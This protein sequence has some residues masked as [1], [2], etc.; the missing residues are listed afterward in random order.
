MNRHSSSLM[1]A[2]SVMGIMMTWGTAFYAASMCIGPTAS[3]CFIEILVTAV[4]ITFM[5][6]IVFAE[7]LD[8]LL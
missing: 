1:F 5:L 3:W 2:A 8:N 4:F 6:G 7:S